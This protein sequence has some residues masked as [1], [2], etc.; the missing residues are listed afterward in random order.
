MVLLPIFESQ[1]EF[2]EAVTNYMN[3]NKQTKPADTKEVDLH[4]KIKLRYIL[5]TPLRRVELK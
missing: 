4:R 1:D 2:E 3:R 5:Q